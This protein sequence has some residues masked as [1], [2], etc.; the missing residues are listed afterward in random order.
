MGQP[1]TVH[2]LYIVELKG[3]TTSVH[4]WHPKIQGQQYHCENF[5]YKVTVSHMDIPFPC[6]WHMELPSIMAH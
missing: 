3:S 4:Q 6:S 1:R 5:P 2:T